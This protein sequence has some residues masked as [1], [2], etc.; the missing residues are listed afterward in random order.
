MTWYVI[1]GIAFMVIGVLLFIKGATMS[2]GEDKRLDEHIFAQQK[3]LEML[4]NE[5]KRADEA[6]ALAAQAAQEAARLAARPAPKVVY[7]TVKVF[8]ENS[9]Q[10]IEAL[11]RLSRDEALRCLLFTARETIV[12]AMGNAENCANATLALALQNRI[13]GIDTIQ[14]QL[15]TAAKAFDGYMRAKQGAVDEQAS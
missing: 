15:N 13:A 8:E 9:A 3:A 1:S 5:K 6:Q 11:A 4:K 2:A 7:T 10:Y 12:G 14:E